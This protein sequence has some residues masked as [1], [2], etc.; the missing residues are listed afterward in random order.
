VKASIDGEDERE[1][2]KLEDVAMVKMRG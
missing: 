1:R 2:E